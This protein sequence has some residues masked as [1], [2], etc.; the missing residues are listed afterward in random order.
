MTSLDDKETQTISLADGRT[1]AYAEYGNLT[2]TPII[3]MHGTPSCRLEYR[4][5]ESSAK[6]LNARLIAPDRPGMGLSTNSP[7]RTLLDWPRDV[8]TLTQQLKLDRYHV[9]GGSGGGPFALACAKELPKSQLL[10][11]NVWAGAGPPE[12]GLKG[13]KSRLFSRFYQEGKIRWQ[14]RLSQAYKTD[15]VVMNDVFLFPCICTST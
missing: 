8:Q 3:C 5:W 9:L 4:L 12:I 14:L 2:G 15:D 6:K 13:S 10:S 1:L 11:V 7:G